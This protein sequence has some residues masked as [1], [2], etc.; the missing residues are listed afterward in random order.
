MSL[1]FSEEGGLVGALVV[2]VEGG[3][4]VGR[5]EVGPITW[6]PQGERRQSVIGYIMEQ[7]GN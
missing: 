6:P 5:P 7:H 2:Y 4:Y 1:P 3:A